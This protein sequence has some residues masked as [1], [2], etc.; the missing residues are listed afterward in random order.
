MVVLAVLAV[1]TLRIVLVGKAKSALK[2]AYT[3]HY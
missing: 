1:L 3:F 2:Q